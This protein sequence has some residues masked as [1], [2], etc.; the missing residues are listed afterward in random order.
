MWYS[1]LVAD[2]G[3]IPL[4]ANLVG[5]PLPVPSCAEEFSGDITELQLQRL[6]DKRLSAESGQLLMAGLGVFDFDRVLAWLVFF[7]HA[8]T[9][10]RTAIGADLYL[11]NKKR[12]PRQHDSY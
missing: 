11:T 12:I 9:G 8:A 7:G 3:F 5:L 2:G 6:Q 10:V 4:L 1:R